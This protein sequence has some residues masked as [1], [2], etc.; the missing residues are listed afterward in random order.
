MTADASKEITSTGFGRKGKPPEPKTSEELARIA[1]LIADGEVSLLNEI[2]DN[3]IAEVV[4]LV[5]K[6]RRENLLTLISKVISRDLP[7]VPEH[8]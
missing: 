2:A 7:N 8:R 1:R 6:Q 5:R 4:R 3:Q